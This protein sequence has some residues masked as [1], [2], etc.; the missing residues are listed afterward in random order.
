MN[1]FKFSASWCM[2]CKMMK[3]VFE[4]VSKNSKYESLNFIE[5]D[6]EGEDL[7]EKFNITPNDL[8]A[9]YKVRNIPTLII[10]DDDLNEIGKMV[11]GADKN[12]II[13]F[14]DTTLIQKGE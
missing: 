13:S 11:G 4:E 6:I 14:I 5:V 2:P 3:P 7:I 9:K 8:C 1:V 12:K 10:A